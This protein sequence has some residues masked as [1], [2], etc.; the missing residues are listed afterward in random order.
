MI[1]DILFQK[2]ESGIEAAALEL[3]RLATEST[4]ALT[5]IARSKPELLHQLARLHTGWP[6][7]KQRR[8]RLSG[9]E[10]TLFANI[11]LGGDSIIEQDPATAKWKMDDAG[12][13]AYSLL[14]FMDNA[15]K[16][17]PDSSFDYGRLGKAL[18]RLPAF[19]DESAVLWWGAAKDIL[20][21]SYPKPQSII[22]FDQ[23]VL[24]A[25][26]RKS[27]GRIRQAILDMLKAR[28]LSFARNISYPT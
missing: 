22:E 16:S 15:R 14:E 1:V 13:I 17:R 5:R 3:A 26:K 27:P 24:P 6:V 28:F 18:R 25:S 2:A 19:C 12:K 9:S 23:L 8:E 21:F 10:R 20:L 7:I 11:H 4:V